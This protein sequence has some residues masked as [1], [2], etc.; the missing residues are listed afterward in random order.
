VREL[1]VVSKEIREGSKRGKRIK[2]GKTGKREA[3]E[4]RETSGGPDVKSN[5]VPSIASV[6]CKFMA[7]TLTQHNRVQQHQREGKRIN[8]AKRKQ[9]NC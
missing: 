2:S 3:R 6:W 5:S 8:S 4:T 7:S 9:I 1:P